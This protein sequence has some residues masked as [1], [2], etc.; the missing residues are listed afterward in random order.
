MAAPAEPRI[1]DPAETLSRDELAALQLDRLRAV[2]DRVLHAQPPGAARL[3]AA[4]ITAAADLRSLD[5]LAALPL[6]SK[7]DLR[8]H[9]PFGLLAV[10]RQDLVRIHASSGTGGKPTVV[11]YTASDLE[12]WTELMARCLTLAGVSRG[13]VIHNANGYG[14]FT[15][16]LG[17]HQGAERIGA[18]VIPVSGGF[19]SRQAM[20]LTDLGADV[21]AATPSYALVIAQALR[22]RGERP[23][24]RLGLF[25]GEPWTEQMRAELEQALP[26]LAAVSFYGLSEMF[27]PG[28]A[29]ECLEERRGLHVH[30]DHFL[31]EVVD[32][33]TE[34]PVPAGS[35][36]ELVFTSLSSEA[37]PL[38]R[39]RT[40]DI[41]R[42]D[43]APCR[44]GRTTARLTGLRGRRDDM[45]IIR[46]VN[47]HPS[48]VEHVL[49]SAGGVAPHYRIIAERPGPLDELTVE[50][51][52]A[53][54]TG[55]TADEL[56]RRLAHLLREQ[57]G[58]RLT[59]AVLPTGSIP[60]S[61]CKAVR[62][63][64]RR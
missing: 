44:C 31:V 17:F 5:D 27:G 14:L 1:R 20:L 59:V 28:V 4:G 32:P 2:T 39:Y 64:D 38:L 47:V 10:P 6:L 55:E 7:A 37:L 56:T 42:L 52:P 45:L 23:R 34:R 16:G 57:T 54:E 19:T 61:E 13:M 36:G 9:Y 29:T 40:G 53:A 35:E 58:L 51:E 33:A 63:I 26:G 48:Q 50:C 49:L 62:V 30:E 15:G 12:T 41:G 24:L 60:R 18:Q 21:L 3:R 25:G 22:D 43:A 8:E 46:G 11:G